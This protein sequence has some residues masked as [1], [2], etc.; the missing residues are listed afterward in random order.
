MSARWEPGD[1]RTGLI[2]LGAFVCLVGGVIWAN[3]SKVQDVSHLYAEFPTLAGVSTETPVLLNGFRVG[4]VDEITP[5]TD[6]LGRLRFRVRMS[7]QWH[8][9]GGPGV[10]YRQGMRVR[11]IPPAIEM[12]GTALIKLEPPVTPGVALRK[13]ATI[14]T[15]PYVSPF[16]V[17]QSRV[18]SIGLELT[19]TLADTRTLLA[20]LA[21]TAGAATGAAVAT[22]GVANTAN[23]QLAAL[24]G[25]TR[26]R[27][28][29]VD[30]LMRDVRAL[31]PSARA[32]ADSL[33]GMLGDS[34]RAIARLTRLADANEPQ[35]TRT[36]ASLDTSSVLLQHFIR[37]VSARPLRVLTGVAP[38]APSPPVAVVP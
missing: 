35:L 9:G 17:A 18:D 31:T 16:E 29:T 8:P 5:L 32:T 11:L 12:I 30:S 4:T 2:V 28:L 21:R 36:L 23:E 22:A 14:P 38:A 25:D 33:Q 15:I 19:R 24:A 20:V 26:L 37:Q 13:D 27:L 10:P 34:R 6:S 3:T 7:V 1:L